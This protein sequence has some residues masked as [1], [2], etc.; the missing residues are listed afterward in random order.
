MELKKSDHEEHRDIE[1]L[2]GLRWMGVGDYLLRLDQD[3][4]MMLCFEVVYS[5]ERSHN[6][7]T[8]PENN[9][10]ERLLVVHGSYYNK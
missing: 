8:N 9:A 5:R 10:C 4:H 7:G 3:Q 1:I 2:C 6:C